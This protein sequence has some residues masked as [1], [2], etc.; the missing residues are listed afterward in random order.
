MQYPEHSGRAI[1]FGAAREQQLK[2]GGLGCRWS[3]TAAIAATAAAAA[4]AS[5]AASAAG[6]TNSVAITLTA[7]IC[8]VCHRCRGFCSRCSCRRRCWRCWR[9]SQ[10]ATLRCEAP[11]HRNRGPAS[12]RGQRC[13]QKIAE[14]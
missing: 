7:F 13:H 6:G 4:A 8:Q 3:T 5:A 2:R 14:F 10:P 11:Q 12:Q 1:E 9:S